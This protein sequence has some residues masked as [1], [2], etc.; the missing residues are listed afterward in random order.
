VNIGP[1]HYRY[2]DV[3]NE[4]GIHLVEKTYQV[5]RETPGGYW[6]RLIGGGGKLT[7]KEQADSVYDNRRTARGVKFVLKHS[8]R[9]HCYPT[10]L[11]AMESFACRKAAQIRHAEASLVKARHSLAA[12]NRIASTGLDYQTCPRTRSIEV[13]MP[14][15]YAGV[16]WY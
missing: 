11:E 9:R 15:E 12:A 13:G 7:T 8:G 3:L 2:Q 5:I 1:D 6:V 10:K 16:T 4:G 14:P